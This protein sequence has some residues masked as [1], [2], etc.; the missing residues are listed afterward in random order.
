MVNR[1]SFSLACL[2]SC[3]SLWITGLAAAQSPSL[4]EVLNSAP[5]NANAVIYADFPSL[6]KVTGDS[7]YNIE[8]L[9][10]LSEA[11]IVAE[12]NLSAM[13]PN[14]EVGYVS[15]PALPDPKEIASLKRGYLEDMHGKKVVWT[16][17]AGYLVPSGTDLLGLVRPA[18]RQLLGS[19]LSGDSKSTPPA[20]LKSSAEES[21]QFI[22]LLVAFDI[23]DWL[24]PS[25]AKQRLESME[26]L[27][28][29]NLDDLSKVIAGIEGV[30][31]IVGRRNLDE[32]I[33][34]LKFSSHP[35]ILLPHVK[36][37]FEEVMAR[38]GVDVSEAKTWTATIDGDSIAL[39]GRISPEN[40]DML[41]DTFS[42]QRRS[43]GHGGGKPADSA[44]SKEAVA[45][46]SFFRSVTDITKK[47]REYTKRNTASTSTSYN[48][49]MAR[50]IDE[51]GTLDVDPVLL[52]YAGKVSAQLRGFVMS[53]RGVNV[54]AGVGTMAARSTSSGIG[55]SY[56]PY[57]YGGGVGGFYGGYGGYYS[58][59]AGFYNPNAPLEA[60][61]VINQQAKGQ[62]TV[63]YSQVTASID[64]LTVE[65]RRMMTEKYKIQF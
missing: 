14:W 20:F 48:D 42:V 18:N 51:L 47:V 49:R 59:Y 4:T 16:P 61:N 55:E 64:E 8:S 56:V 11:R 31:I 39:R 30:R 15:V 41:L 21:T 24:A 53:A 57:A 13:V 50:R 23:K 37:L 27:R 2:A 52:D 1:R 5:A 58:G 12:L 65:V 62:N 60:A 26:F 40:I 34:T 33:V 25:A 54:Q 17:D 10:K 9:K 3:F 7:L 19:W 22:S 36:R 63:A 32:C 28:D 6:L 38:A 29:A 44:A 35:N 46:L 45:S 43:P